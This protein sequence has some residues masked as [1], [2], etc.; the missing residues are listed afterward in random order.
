MIFIKKR[1]RLKKEEILICQCHSIEH[2][3]V[4]LYDDSDL[5]D[6]FVYMNIH[7]QKQPLWRRI[8]YAI[9]YIFGHQSNVG[10]F[11]EIILD[12]EDVPKLERLVEYLKK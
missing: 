7:L 8:K 6:Q 2:S 1:N 10:A 9:K 4:F 11:N 12:K 3:I 5:D